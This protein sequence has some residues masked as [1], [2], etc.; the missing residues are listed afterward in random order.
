MTTDTT[1][2]SRTL[3]FQGIQVQID[4]S[5][6]SSATNPNG[7]TFDVQLDPNAAEDIKTAVT[8]PK[9][10]AASADT[11]N[12]DSSNNSVVFNVNGAVPS[13]T[14][15]IPSGIYTNDPGQPDDISAALESAIKTAYQNSTGSALPDTLNVAYNPNTK[16]FNITM[17]S[18]GDTINLMWSNSASTAK[19]IFGFSGDNNTLVSAAAS[20]V[21]DNPASVYSTA[22]KGAPGD[23]RNA[24]T[25]AGLVNGTELAGTTP[26][27]M[28]M[29]LVSNVG[30]NASAANTNLQYHSTLATE[31]TQQQ[32]QLSGVSMDQE[33]SNLVVY[34]KSYEAAAEL[35][36]T[37]EALLT[38]LLQM[39]NPNA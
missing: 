16:Q 34:Q 13:I 18:G 3:E 2:L 27:D 5:G 29:S 32:Q 10:V 38:T 8:D 24:A 1:G 35:I 11:W 20:A 22:Q 15:V 30:V 33:A 9:Q 19:Q 12:I 37:A 28:Y 31:L 7:E 6:I 21:S 4:G 36:T 39:V 23:N 14:A 26:T 17:P 25:I